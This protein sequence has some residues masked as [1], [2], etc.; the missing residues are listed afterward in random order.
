MWKVIREMYNTITNLKTKILPMSLGDS[1]SSLPPSARCLRVCVAWFVKTN[2]FLCCWICEKDPPCNDYIKSWINHLYRFG[3]NTCT[4][5]KY[6]VRTVYKRA[7]GPVQFF[8]VTSNS[9][10]I[11]PDRRGDDFVFAIVSYWNAQFS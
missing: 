6:F 10:R 9:F 8:T 5:L 3:L 11:R 7:R 4:D 2:H 1:T